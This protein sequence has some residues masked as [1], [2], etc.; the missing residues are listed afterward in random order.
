M[1]DHYVNNSSVFSRLGM[2]QNLNSCRLYW[3]SS[4]FTKLSKPQ[5][6]SLV[7]CFLV[8]HQLILKKLN[9]VGQCFTSLLGPTQNLWLC[10]NPISLCWNTLAMLVVN[11]S[12]CS[13]PLPQFCCLA[14]Q[15]AH[16]HWL[17]MITLLHH[18]S[19]HNCTVCTL[20]LIT[21]L[22]Q[23]THLLHTQHNK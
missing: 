23:I 12:T 15:Q 16:C 13:I 14:D 9:P 22:H 18:L 3:Q 2:I 19:T 5:P 21:P 10:T 11:V 20:A 17:H 4:Q 8:S 7:W 6:K 1:V